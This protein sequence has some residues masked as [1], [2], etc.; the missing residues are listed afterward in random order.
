M[1]EAVLSLCLF[2]CKATEDLDQDQGID[3]GGYSKV[4]HHQE[5]G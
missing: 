4:D 1:F 3:L 5:D 2:F